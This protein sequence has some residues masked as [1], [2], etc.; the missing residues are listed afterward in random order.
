MAEPEVETDREIAA[1][2]NIMYGHELEDSPYRTHFQLLCDTAR[3]YAVADKYN[4]VCAKEVAASHFKELN[5]LSGS[6]TK[7]EF[8]RLNV[9][10]ESS[11]DE[12]DRTLRNQ[13]LW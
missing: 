11:T 9:L 6:L 2:L 1:M 12:D 13:Q 3:L 5:K 7:K 8:K 4:V 10:I